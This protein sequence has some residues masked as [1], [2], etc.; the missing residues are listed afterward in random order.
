MFVSSS[1]ILIQQNSLHIIQNS[2]MKLIKNLKVNAFRPDHY[3]Y[4]CDKGS[5]FMSQF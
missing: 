4:K 3:K 1:P 2:D 5:C